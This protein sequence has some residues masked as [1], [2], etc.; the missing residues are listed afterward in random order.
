MANKPDKFG[1]KFFHVVDL[2]TKYVCNGIPY[3]GKSEDRP[4]GEGLAFHLVKKLLV[5]YERR[6]H[7]IT[8]K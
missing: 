5:P 2:K 4:E 3:L 8:G 1:L 6:G 7:N